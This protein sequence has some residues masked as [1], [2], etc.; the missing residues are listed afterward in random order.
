MLSCHVHCVVAHAANP[1]S[2]SVKHCGNAAG[3]EHAAMGSKLPVTMAIKKRR[4]C[5]RVRVCRAQCLRARRVHERGRI[6][7]GVE[8]SRA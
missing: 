3:Q 4:C 1:Q 2:P 6:A 7:Q 5:M 8:I